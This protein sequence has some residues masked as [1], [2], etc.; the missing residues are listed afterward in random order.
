MLQS[1][2]QAL[3]YLWLFQNCQPAERSGHYLAITG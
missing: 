1:L 2:W 3:L